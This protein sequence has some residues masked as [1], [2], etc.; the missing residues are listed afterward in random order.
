[1]I[2][3]KPVFD[4]ATLEKGLEVSYTRRWEYARGAALIIPGTNVCCIYAATRGEFNKILNRVII[5]SEI[6][7]EN[8]K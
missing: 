5:E 1:M 7:K 3:I 2:T 4:F 6:C 8:E